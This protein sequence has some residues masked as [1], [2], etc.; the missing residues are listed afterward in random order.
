MQEGRLG[1]RLYSC[2]NNVRHEKMPIKVG[3]SQNPV[4]SLYIQAYT[5]THIYTCIHTHMYTYHF[6]DFIYICIL[7]PGSG[8]A[9]EERNGNPLQYSCLENPIDRGAWRAIVH[10]AAKS[11]T[12]LTL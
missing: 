7:I 6:W 4:C 8:R 9:P 5:H 10:R 12:Q 2:V 1:Q 11:Q 3:Y